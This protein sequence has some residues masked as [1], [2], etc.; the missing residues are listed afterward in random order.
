MIRYERNMSALSKE[1]NEKLK[2]FRVV[3]VGCGGLGSYTV[4]MLAR[5][6]IGHITVVDGDSFSESNLN[7][8]ILSNNQNLG[9]NKA[10]EAKKRMEIVNELIEVVPVTK[11]IDEYN[12]TDI[13]KGHHIVIDGLDNIDTRFLLQEKCEELKIPFVHGAIGGWY[14]QVTTIFPG[15]RTLDFIYRNRRKEGIEKRFG[16]PSFIPALVSSIQVSETIKVLIKRG[17]ILRKKLLVI[18]LLYQDF[19]IINFQ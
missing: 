18:D 19:K 6:G 11:F 2:D 15:D 16:N 7:R 10:V 4:E 3:V 8:Q 9:K 1:E 13:L 17:E 14:G 12:G 5:L